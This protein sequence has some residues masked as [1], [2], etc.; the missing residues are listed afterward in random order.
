M[1]RIIPVAEILTILASGDFDR[2]LGGLEDEHLECKGAPYRLV[3]DAAKME[4]AKDISALANSD[5][6]VILSS[7]VTEKNPTFR[8]R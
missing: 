6:R 1:P 4:F 7:I 3:D 2:L 5:G 8:R